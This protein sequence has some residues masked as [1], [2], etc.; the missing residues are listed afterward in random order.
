MTARSMNSSAPQREKILR[1]LR[2]ARGAGL[3]ALALLAWQISHQAL[4]NA[5]INF[6]GTLINAPNC[7]VNGNNSVDVNFG[8]NIVTRQVD[9]NNYKTRIHYDLVCTS[10]ASKGLRVA[11]S[12]NPAAFGIGLLSA[13]K[14]GL[15][16]QL[17]NGVVKVANAEQLPFTYPDT[18]EL[19]AT[20][21]A[22]D[23]TTLTAGT[24]SSTASLVLS[25]Q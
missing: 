10:M 7:T 6:S 21:V 17:W 25:Y 24:F 8:D 19:W 3:I 12:G 13:G 1:R 14:N 5:N 11:I 18:P 16:I 15:A 23:N 22:L 2:F 9:G 4:A 20:P